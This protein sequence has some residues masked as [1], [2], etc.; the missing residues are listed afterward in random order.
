MEGWSPSCGHSAFPSVSMTGEQIGWLSLGVAGTT[1]YGVS[2]LWG[3]QWFQ[4]STCLQVA[5]GPW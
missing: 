5:W 1:L 3:E 4:T 2:L